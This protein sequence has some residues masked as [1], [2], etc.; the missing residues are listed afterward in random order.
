MLFLLGVGQHVFKLND[1]E[2]SK[3]SEVNASF[4]FRIKAII[5]YYENTKSQVENKTNNTKKPKEQTTKKNA[6]YKFFNFSHVNI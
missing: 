6:L 2:K 5:H 3:R 1:I 4:W